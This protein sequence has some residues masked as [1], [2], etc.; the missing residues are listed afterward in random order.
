MTFSTGKKIIRSLLSNLCDKLALCFECLLG[1]G[2]DGEI[3][4]CMYIIEDSL[5]ESP[6]IE[7]PKNSR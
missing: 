6:R 7:K 5:L 2:L 1:H 3:F 4:Y